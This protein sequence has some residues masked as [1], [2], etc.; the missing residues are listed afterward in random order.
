LNQVPGPLKKLGGG[1]QRLTSVGSGQGGKLFN[2]D[3]R[4]S[5]T[6][7]HFDRIR[8][9]YIGDRSFYAVFH[10]SLSSFSRAGWRNDSVSF[11][12]QFRDQ[13]TADRSGSPCNKYLH[14]RTSS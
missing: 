10:K 12:K 11:D 2:H 5:A 3:V 1:S 14:R 7:G 13:R 4:L 8:I 6:D 9:K